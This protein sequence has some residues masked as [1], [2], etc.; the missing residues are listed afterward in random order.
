MLFDD[1]VAFWIFA[2]VWVMAI[3]LV[4]LRHGTRHAEFKLWSIK[5]QLP[6]IVGDSVLVGSEVELEGTIGVGHLEVCGRADQILRTKSSHHFLID[7]KLRRSH[8]VTEDDLIQVSVYDQ[9]MTESQYQPR[10]DFAFIR[11]VVLNETGKTIRYHN[12]QLLGVDQLNA[13]SDSA[14]LQTGLVREKKTDDQRYK[15]VEK[16]NSPQNDYR[17]SLDFRP[18]R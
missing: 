4:D 18:V 17:G 9:L 3:L 11:T 5:E 7:T 14:L 12:V 1:T 10:C 15:E 13:L 2:A 16:D 6:T 8:R